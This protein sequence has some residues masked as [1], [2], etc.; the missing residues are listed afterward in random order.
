MDQLVVEYLLD[1]FEVGITKDNKFGNDGALPLYVLELSQV[2]KNFTKNQFVKFVVL[3]D[4]VLENIN[5]IPLVN[6]KISTFVDIDVAQAVEYILFGE[7]TP[8]TLCLIYDVEQELMNMH[9][10][11]VLSNDEQQITSVIQKEEKITGSPINFHTL[12]PL[13]TDKFTSDPV[14]EMQVYLD[15]VYDSLLSEKFLTRL[16]ALKR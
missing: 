9:C 14:S 13:L 4:F 10:I 12:V 3:F 7:K 15:T 11:T 2:V 1:I 16:N 6:Q 5:D 8:F